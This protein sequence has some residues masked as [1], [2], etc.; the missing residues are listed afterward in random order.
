MGLWKDKVGFGAQ[1]ADMKVNDRGIPVY[2]R[3]YL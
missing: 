1:H 3:N 2:A